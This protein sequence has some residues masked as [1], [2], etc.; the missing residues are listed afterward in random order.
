M[1][2]I[3]FSLRWLLILTAL[4]AVLLYILLL[5]PVA[6]AKQFTQKLETPSTLESVIDQYFGK[7]IRMVNV[8]G[9]LQERT[10]TDIYRCRQ[11]FSIRLKKPKPNTNGKTV[12]ALCRDFYATPIGVQEMPGPTVIEY[13]YSL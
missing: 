9:E 13:R 11:R 6:M 5:R 7:N 1:R 2:I 3:R 10:W 12:L 4:V 8:E